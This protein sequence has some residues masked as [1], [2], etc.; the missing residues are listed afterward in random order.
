MRYRD[1]EDV[2]RRLGEAAA[3]Q[4][5]EKIAECGVRN[6][7]K[8]GN[9]EKNGKHGRDG[10]KRIDYGAH[11]K[12]IHGRDADATTKGMTKTEGRYAERLLSR[13]QCGAIL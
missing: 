2:W 6:A 9:D 7:E 3:R 5:E 8:N 1:I 13:Q 11:G 10:K 4:A 12:G